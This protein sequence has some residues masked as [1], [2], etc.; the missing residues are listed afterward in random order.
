MKETKWLEENQK[1]VTL[2][3]KISIFKAFDD[4]DFQGLLKISK[5][6]FYRPG[7]F[8]IME[9]STETFIYFLIRGTVK[10]T[11]N[12]KTITTLRRRGDIFG[13]MGVVEIAPRSAAAY[14]TEDTVCLATD[15]MSIKR[16]SGKEKLSLGY[17]FYRII[18]EILVNRLKTTTDELMK[19]VDK[20]GLKSD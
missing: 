14:A 11:K 7:E 10:I 13:E 15:F 18:S 17:L 5:L 12:K 1:I 20:K 9:G 19:Y 8:I 3:K 6:H 16:I 2:L 4:E